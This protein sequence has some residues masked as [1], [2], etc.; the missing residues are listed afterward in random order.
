MA[1]RQGKAFPFWSGKSAADLDRPRDFRWILFG[2]E[3]AVVAL[4]IHAKRSLPTEM[5]LISFGKTGAGEGIRTLDPNLGNV[6]KIL[7]YC[8]R[9]THIVSIASLAFGALLL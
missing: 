3:H 8:S 1:R 5:L 9:P 6:R 7:S 2:D 4:R